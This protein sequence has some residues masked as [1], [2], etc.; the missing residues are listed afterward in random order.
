MA[1]KAKTD[2]DERMDAR[3]QQPVDENKYRQEFQT[4][5]TC[6]ECGAAVEDIRVTCP[7]C[8]YE[9]RDEDYTDPDAGT[10]LVTGSHVT[11]RGED[12]TDP[13]YDPAGED[14]EPRA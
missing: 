1:G 6:P 12:I 9:Y 11:E 14:A 10:E 5:K 2:V 8:G 13:S 7:N 4:D 3:R